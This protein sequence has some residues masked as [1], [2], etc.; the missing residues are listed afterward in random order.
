MFSL[1]RKEFNSFFGSITGYLVIIIFLLATGL[2]LWVLPGSF[3]IIEGQRATL[4]GFFDLAPW[5]YL[6]LIPAITMRMFAEEKRTGTIEMLITRPLTAFQITFAKYLAAL[7]LVCISLAPTLLNFY[8]VYQLGNPAG[9]IDTGATWGSF[10][11]LL[12]L[13]SVYIGIGLFASIITGNQVVAFLTAITLSFI[14]YNG[15]SFLTGIDLS[16]PVQNF[17]LQLGIHEHYLSI[18]RGI[19]DSRDIFYFLFATFIFLLLTRNMLRKTRLFATWNIKRAAL[20]VLLLIGAY[21]SVSKRLFRID[22]TAEKRYSLSHIT[23]DILQNQNQPLGIEVYLAG[24][25]PSGMKEFQESIIEKIE[26]MNAYS[27]YRLFHEVID[28]Y[29]ISNEEERENTIKALTDAGIEPVNFGHKTTEGMSTKQIFPGIVISNRSQ[30]VVVNLLKNNPLISSNDNLQHSIE[31]LEYEFAAAIKGLQRTH[32]PRIAFLDKEG[33]A[34]PYETGDIRYTLSESYEVVDRNTSEIF[35]DDTVKTL[36]I[37]APT[38]SFTETE[39]LQ[40]DQFIMKGG[41]VLWCVDPIQVSIDSLSKGHSTI[42]FEKGLNLRDQLFRYGI[43][44]N[45]DI[46]QDAFCLDYPINTAPPGK[47]SQFTPAPFYYAPLALPNPNHPLSRNL[48]NVVIE[49]ASSVSVV[50]N[51]TKATPIL[52]TSPYARSVQ[53]PVEVSLF[54]ATNPP[55]QRLFNQPNI[56]I[57]LL[58]E[59]RFESAFKNRMTSQYGVSDIIEKSPESKMIV[60]ADGGIIK[61]K[62]RTRGGNAQILP[63]GYDQYS[64]RT[65]GNRDFLQNCIDYLTDDTSIMELRS[66]VVKLRMLDKVKIREEQLRWQLINTAVPLLFFILTGLA[67]ALI[68][69]KMYCKKRA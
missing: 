53:T 41:H 50:G 12:F 57:G 9:N 68:R 62:V 7:I 4:K 5:L 33:N 52:A 27:P 37:A 19:I 60:I 8:S 51:N 61:N 46:L 45:T 38:R 10:A 44:L 3:N 25:L 66:R 23:K 20:L 26:D 16:L 32:K 11:G 54:S 55:D 48:N 34:T 15:F 47:A 18:S 67:Y 42:A 13:A 58:V 29:K 6:F 65:F 69:K 30:S 43:R 28:V 63:L 56:P 59:G 21:T 64:G 39:K 49:F 35:S 2:F 24:N 17:L 14:M 36:I 31:L 40:I 22:L 1:L